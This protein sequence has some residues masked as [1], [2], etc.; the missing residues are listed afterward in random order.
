LNKTDASNIP[1]S[2]LIMGSANSGKMQ[3]LVNQFCGPFCGRFDYVVLIC[4]I[5]ACN[6]TLDRFADRDPRLFDII[7]EKHEVEFW[8]KVVS[9][10]FEGANTP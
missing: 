5:F 6:K 1:F 2:V 8:L 7:C 9:M 4:L 3:F 10:F